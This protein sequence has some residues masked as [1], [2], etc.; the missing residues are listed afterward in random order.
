MASNKYTI[1]LG[2]TI[3]LSTSLMAQRNDAGFDWKDSSK[4]ATK[5]MPQYNEFK[6]NEYP[7]P[8]QPR[9]QWELGLSAGAAMIIGDL[10][11]LQPG[12]TGGISLRKAINHTFSVRGSYLGSLNK[13]Y[14]YNRRT[15]SSVVFT[16]VINPWVIYNAAPN[17]GSFYANYRTQMHQGSIE[18]LASLFNKSY[19]RGNPKWDGYVFAGYSLVSADVDINATNASGAAYNF[20]AINVNGSRKDIRDAIK[21]LLDDSYEN[22]AIAV[23]G[24]R[25]NIGRFDDNQLIRHGVSAGFGLTRKLNDRINIGIEQRFTTVFDDNLDGI[26][27]GRANDLISYST[28]RLNINLGK[29]TKRVAPLWWINPNNYV[30]NEINKPQHM[31]LP[32]VVLPDADKDGV[33]DQFDLEPNTPEGAPVDSHGRAKDSDGDGIPDYKDKE[34]LTSQ[35]CFPVNADGV[36]NCPEPEC[37]KQIREEMKNWEKKDTKECNLTSLPSVTFKAKSATVSKDAEAIL[38]GAAAQIKANPNCKVKVTSYGNSDKRA[39]QLS[40]DRVNAVIR[41]MV[42]KQAISEDRFIFSYGQDGEEANTVDLQAT[43]EDGPNTVTAPH[44]N[45][46]KS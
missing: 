32:K 18:V 20:S 2:L 11:S 37:C 16:N 36:G 6:N 46:K 21:N 22:N 27:A 43:T 38:A 31:K 39:Q 17:G 34:L 5:N 45:L 41:Y 40:W 14:D 30:Y 13:G 4:I 10:S 19:Y 24:N 9:N 1:I 35:K 23:G 7:Y 15:V 12:I 42:E 44:P 26:V 25:R 8:A 29:T 28:A 3:L 33:T